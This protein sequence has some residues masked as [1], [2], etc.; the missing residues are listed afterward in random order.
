MEHFQWTNHLILSAWTFGMRAALRRGPTQQWTK[1]QKAILTSLENITG[2]ANLTFSLQ[3]TSEMTAWFAFLRFFIPN[4][5][6]NWWLSTEEAEWKACWL[7]VADKLAS[8][9]GFWKKQ[10]RTHITSRNYNGYNLWHNNQERERNILLYKG[11]S[12]PCPW[13]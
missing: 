6:Q 10:E 13:W 12:L 2:F 4:G 8:L 5:F 3:E 11:R 7:Q 9:T 1:D